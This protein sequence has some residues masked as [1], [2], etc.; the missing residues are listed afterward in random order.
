MSK[1]NL[2]KNS[3]P[4]TMVAAAFI[5]PG[6]VTMC[7]I[8]GAQFG[9]SLLWAMVLS[10]ISTIV[11][12]GMA[13]R[14]GLI[15]QNG[16]GE[17]IVSKLKSKF[18]RYAVVTLVVSAVIIGNSAYQAGNITG[19]VLGLETFLPQ[20]TFNFNNFDL[21]FLPL[22]LGAV[23]FVLL[24]IGNYKF[25]ERTLVS[26]VILMSISFI[27]TALMTQPDWGKMLTGSLVPSIPS[28]SLLTIV[29]LIGTT[30]VPYNLFL[31]ASLVQEK[32][33]NPSDLKLI[34]KDTLISISLGG[35]V[36]VAIIVCA[37]SLPTTTIKSATDLA[38]GLEPIY[39][40]YAN[41][42]LGIGLFAAGLT[43]AITAP[44][45]AA[46]VARGCFGWEKNLKSRKFRATWILVLIVGVFFS[47][48]GKN[49]IEIITFAQVSNGIL[50]PIIAFFLWWIVNKSDIMGIY[51]N[52]LFQNILSGIIILVTFLIT[53][54][55]IY[56]IFI[57]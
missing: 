23:T 38:A 47:M 2:L 44:L 51:K 37:A 16:L 55:M 39:G 45:A 46:Y 17:A 20:L 25:I 21:N 24:F 3:G 48:A 50:L 49:P 26:L 1:L 6:T 35:L 14:L 32:W 42:F 29:G 18:V 7:S 53:C 33:K 11:L 41:Y 43:S 27:V 57:Q 52:T 28:G 19:G 13:A 22:I 31:H 56:T 30:I 40:N 4:G 9:Y 5:G 10:I 54:R 15:Y 8:A 36:S 12:Q 34:K